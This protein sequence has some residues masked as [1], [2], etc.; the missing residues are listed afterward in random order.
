MARHD[1]A[2]EAHVLQSFHEDGYFSGF[3]QRAHGTL[4]DMIHYVM[5]KPN[6]YRRNVGIFVPSTGD[7]LGPDEIKNSAEDPDY[8]A[9]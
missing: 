2:A 4:A 3:A 7:C 9:T 1:Y 5:T 8:P 6:T